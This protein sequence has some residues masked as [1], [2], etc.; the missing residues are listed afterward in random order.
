MG[1]PF[2][3]P[4]KAEKIKS[5]DEISEKEQVER[6][7]NLKVLFVDK[8]KQDELENQ[9]DRNRANYID[10]IENIYKY[11]QLFNIDD[12]DDLEK[13]RIFDHAVSGN[14]IIKQ[15]L[16]FFL[17]VKKI[18]IANNTQDK[19]V[20]DNARGKISLE[21]GTLDNLIDERGYGF[22]DKT[23]HQLYVDKLKNLFHWSLEA[24]VAGGEKIG[25]TPGIK[26][27]EIGVLCNDLESILKHVNVGR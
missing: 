17:V 13:S 1:N 27:E 15:A 2:E 9:G 12:K 10:F 23:S 20:M 3:Q 25:R 26:K 14:R 21:S 6:F 22:A 18:S 5:F 16:E 19:R 24:F 7:K 11:P 8:H 4:T